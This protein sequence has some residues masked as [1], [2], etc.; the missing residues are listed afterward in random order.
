VVLS[1]EQ[2]HAVKSEAAWLL[3]QW[4]FLHPGDMAYEMIERYTQSFKG[5]EDKLKRKSIATDELNF[6]DSVRVLAQYSLINN[7]EGRGSFY[8]Y[9]VVHEWSLYNVVNDQARERLCMQAIRIVAESIPSSKDPGDLH[10]AR[11]L[12]PYARMVVTRYN[13]MREVANI[14]IELY[15]IAHLMQD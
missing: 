12:I 5:S 6:Q 1:Y 9:P 4:A 10:A 15:G 2:V 3:D 11:K 14:E 8:I 13:K 7:T